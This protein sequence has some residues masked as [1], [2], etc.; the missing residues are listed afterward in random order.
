MHVVWVNG[1][2]K[3]MV[4][5]ANTTLR[6]SNVMAGRFWLCE[7]RLVALCCGMAG[8]VGCVLSWQG[9]ERLV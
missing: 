9:E 4:C 3:E 7:V 6:Q 2:P 5:L 1:D 8:E